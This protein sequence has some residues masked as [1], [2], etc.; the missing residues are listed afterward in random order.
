MEHY[1]VVVRGGSHFGQS[2]EGGGSGVFFIKTQGRANTFLRKKKV[3]P[4]KCSSTVHQV[5]SL[6]FGAVRR[7]RARLTPNFLSVR[8][9]IFHSNIVNE[10]TC[11]TRK[12]RCLTWAD[13]L[14]LG[15]GMGCRSPYVDSDEENFFS[16]RPE[17]YLFVTNHRK[18]FRLMS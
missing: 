2:P 1:H 11:S 5:C 13:S 8:Q 10:V 6:L 14:T 9:S 7:I 16:C 12:H 17:C 18:S 3:V 4:R 15:T